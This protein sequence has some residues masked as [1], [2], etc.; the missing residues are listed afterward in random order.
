MQML[1]TPGS[2]PDATGVSSRFTHQGKESV[3]CAAVILHRC[4]NKFEESNNCKLPCLDVTS[5]VLLYE[6][7]L[8][9]AM[10]ADILPC[11]D[12]TFQECPSQSFC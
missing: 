3:T 7:S 8:P 10:P 1:V 11:R 2:S 9:P 6:S 5:D 12:I 4:M